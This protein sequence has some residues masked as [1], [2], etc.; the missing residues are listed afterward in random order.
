MNEI[1]EYY[2]S[3]LLSL[4]AAL[5]TLGILFHCISSGGIIHTFVVNYMHSICG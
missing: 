1:I 5:G 2:G 3:V 4:T